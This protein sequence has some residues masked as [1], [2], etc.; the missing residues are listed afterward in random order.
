LTS[1]LDAALDL[2]ARDLRVIPERGKHP[3]HP[4]TGEIDPKGWPTLATTDPDTIRRA[5]SGRPDLGVGVVIGQSFLDLDVDPRLF[6]YPD[7]WHDL[8]R[9]R[10]EVPW[11]PRFLGRGEDEGFHVLVRHPGIPVI[12][13]ITAGV[14]ARC[15][16]KLIVMPPT[17]HH[18]TRRPREWEI[19]LD[20][21]SF[22]DLADPWIERQRDRPHPTPSGPVDPNGDWLAGRPAAEYVKLLTGIEVPRNRKV[23]CPAPDHR[24]RNPSFHVYDDGWYCWGCNRGGGIYQLAAMIGGL[25][26]PLRGVDFLT[27]QAALLDLYES[28]LVG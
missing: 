21:A 9:D 1:I 4:L 20:E 7:E 13:R 2:A 28:R 19:D 10:G 17:P 14:S 3:V 23:N 16:N 24:D 25:P 15:G 6:E 5:Y 18:V 22:A 26:L 11:T 27:V 12:E 8:E